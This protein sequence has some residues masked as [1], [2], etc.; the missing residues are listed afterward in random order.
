MKQKKDATYHNEGLFIMYMGDI[1]QH[2]S[3][4]K[5]HLQLIHTLKLLGRV[6][7]L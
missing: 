6:N 7:G 4:Q 2:V 1:L 5:D 3:V